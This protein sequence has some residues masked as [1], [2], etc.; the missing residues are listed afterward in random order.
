MSRRAECQMALDAETKRW[1]AMSCEQLTAELQEEQNYVIE[2]G[3]VQC[4]VEVQ[5]VENTT[6]Y[7]HVFVSVDDGRFPLAYSPLGQSFI[8]GK[9]KPVPS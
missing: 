4:Q 2:I 7:I 6:E 9:G 3:G 1:S 8:T 5:I